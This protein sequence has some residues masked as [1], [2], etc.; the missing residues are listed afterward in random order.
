MWDTEALYLLESQAHFQ[1]ILRAVW[2]K[3]SR[4]QWGKVFVCELWTVGYNRKNTVPQLWNTGKKC[5]LV[6]IACEEPGEV[7]TAS[8]KGE[9]TMYSKSDSFRCL[10]KESHDVDQQWLRWDSWHNKVM[11]SVVSMAVTFSCLIQ[12]STKQT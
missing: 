4:P 7:N 12:D 1:H 5:E 8:P 11:D 3:Q 10:L 6:C 2:Q 9:A